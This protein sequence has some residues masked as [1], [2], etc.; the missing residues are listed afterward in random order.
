MHECILIQSS[1]DTHHNFTATRRPHP[2]LF[3]GTQNGASAAMSQSPTKRQGAGRGPIVVKMASDIFSNELDRREGRP[4]VTLSA[5]P[6]RADDNTAFGG[7]PGTTYT[8]SFNAKDGEDCNA[9]GVTALALPNWS[10]PMNTS[11]QASPIAVLAGTVDA[12]VDV[13]IENELFYLFEYVV[14]NK[15]PVNGC[16][17]DLAASFHYSRHESNIRNNAS[18]FKQVETCPGKLLGEQKQFNFITVRTDMKRVGQTW[19]RRPVV[20]KPSKGDLKRVPLDSVNTNQWSG[21]VTFTCTFWVPASQERGSISVRAKS[22]IRQ[23]RYGAQVPMLQQIDKNARLGV[24]PAVA[25]SDASETSDDD[26]AKEIEDVRSNDESASAGQASLTAG[27]PF[28]KH[29]NVMGGTLKRVR[30][31]AERFDISSPALQPKVKRSRRKDIQSPQPQTHVS[32]GDDSDSTDDDTNG[33]EL[34]PVSDA[35]TITSSARSKGK[36]PASR[37]G[38]PASRKGAS[39]KSKK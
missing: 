23:S 9:I 3:G 22:I 10:E 20:W 1:A 5:I 27:T 14:K 26:D 4:I 8:M 36:Q 29:E 30:G 13:H 6:I 12:N 39:K 17:V 24:P 7:E 32:V 16:S 34:E 21:K 2:P 38:H 28:I 11:Y 33:C 18:E 35:M 15:T 25:N 31:A 19:L 37:T